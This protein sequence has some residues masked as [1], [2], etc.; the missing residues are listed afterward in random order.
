MSKVHNVGSQTTLNSSL[1]SYL[2]TAT[3]QILVQS[4]ILRMVLSDVH[5]KLDFRAGCPAHISRGLGARNSV[6]ISIEVTVLSK[7]LDCVQFAAYLV[8]LQLPYLCY[9]TLM[10][11]LLYIK[12]FSLFFFFVTV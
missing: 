6:L 3:K 4:E 5:S 12:S 1:F 10:C 2:K 7:L 8:T 9:L 11:V